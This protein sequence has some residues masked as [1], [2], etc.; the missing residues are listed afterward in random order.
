MSTEAGSRSERPAVVS[1]AEA[2][3]G[4]IEAHAREAAPEECCGLL[5][6]TA[7]AVVDAI[8][9]PNTAS[10]PRRRYRIAPED[11]FAAIR[12]GRA[13]GIAVVGSYHSHPASAPVPSET[14]R[15][16]AFDHFLFVIVGF[17]GSSPVLR[18]W[19]LDDGNFAAVPLV[20]TP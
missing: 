20:R 10:D 9:T 19:R 1:M 17:A 12:Q 5:L 15:A 2:V 4:A 8:A 3:A 6:G 13:R 18:A 11:H 14:D 16:D 7:D